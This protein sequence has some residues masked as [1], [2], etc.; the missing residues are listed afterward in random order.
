MKRAFVPFLILIAFFGACVLFYFCWFND[1]KYTAPGTQ[2]VGGVLHL[3]SNDLARD[4]VIWL[5]RDWEIYRGVLLSPEDFSETGDMPEPDEY[6]YIGQYSGFEIYANGILTHG[7]HGSATYRLTIILPPETR[8]YTLEL[9][10][11][12]SAHR[13]YINGLLVSE[14]GNP[15]PEHYRSQTGSGSITVQAADRVEII[16]AVS[17]FSHFYSGL[18]YPPAFGVPEAVSNV[19]NTRLTLRLIANTLALVLGL[20]YFGV[21]LLTLREKNK[22]NGDHPMSIS[23]LYYTGL[24]VCYILY[25]CYPIVK[26]LFPSGMA[27]YTVENFAYCL[28]FLFI[29]LISRGLT[30][31]SQK[32][33]RFAGA[34]A[35]FVCSWAVLMPFMAGD[36]LNM[37]MTYSRIIEWYSWICAIYLTII[38]A[39]GFVR[40]KTHS[41]AMLVAMMV[42]NAALIMDIMLPIF[43]PIR[44]GW[45]TEI[46]SGFVVLMIGVVITVEIAGQFR[47]RLA[48]ESRV[49]SVTK[50]LDVQRAYLS[51]LEDKEEETRIAKHDMR[52]HIM[53]IKQLVPKMEQ[54]EKLTAYLEAVDDKQIQLSQTRY[55]D[56]D[57]LNILL[58][59][60][61]ELAH[62]QHTDFVVRAAMPEV[63]NINEI[64]LCVMLS[65]LLE[66]AL[67][68]STK[69]S[70]QQREISVN[71]GCELGVLGIFIRN[72]FDGMPEKK[73]RHFL[74]R[75][76]PGRIG[77]GIAS[78]EGV[79]KKYNGSA[80]F[81]AD[82]ENIF[83]AKIAIPIWEGGHKFE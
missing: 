80:D 73:G 63:I 16:V 40:G 29:L 70:E 78:A 35:V 46:A 6:I 12:Y 79:C 14:M 57:F 32:W 58:G 42:F 3:D 11:I 74:S 64:D 71:I 30:D 53:V 33:F 48:V 62:Q 83:H 9:P 51:I 31:A 17:N 8:S 21:W 7:P 47:L 59:L 4:P 22:S 41:K 54:T 20:L 72:R 65:N 19:L 13:L 37:M 23:P 81:Y 36:N 76:Q 2:P 5:V 56:H 67:D 52:H 43:E 28:M 75:K 38:A 69:L 27:W 34:F 55:C 50:M 18:I 45:F 77:V 39:H 66:N 60:Y 26:T 49:E 1:N 25:T 15:D 61:A 82:A 10:E 68:A 44:F 24:C